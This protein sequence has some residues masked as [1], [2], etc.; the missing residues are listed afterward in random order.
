VTFLGD[1]FHLPRDVLRCHKRLARAVGLRKKQQHMGTHAFC[2]LSRLH[3][4]MKMGFLMMSEWVALECYKR[5]TCARS[6]MHAACIE[7][8]D[9]FIISVQGMHACKNICCV[10]NGPH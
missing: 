7:W 6:C 9:E 2:A 10:W 5:K 4:A 8:Q 1:A 3:E